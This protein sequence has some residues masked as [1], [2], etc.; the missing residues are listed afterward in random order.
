MA[1]NSFEDVDTWVKAHSVE[2]LRNALASPS[3]LHPL[4]RDWATRWL[5]HQVQQGTIAREDEQHDFLRRQTVA[6]EEAAAAARRSAR[7]AVLGG[8]IS[9]AM[10][11]ATAWPYF[12]L[13]ALVERLAK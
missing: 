7:W 12:K 1:F 8:L 3:R 9:L 13:L 6:A 5:Q 4:N 10:L 11:I 2:E